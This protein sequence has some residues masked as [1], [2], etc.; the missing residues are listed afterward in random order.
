[1]TIQVLPLQNMNWMPCLLL[2]PWMNGME[3]YMAM[4]VEFLKMD[5]CDMPFS[6]D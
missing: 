1:M 2:L 5:S 4:L 6:T 3:L